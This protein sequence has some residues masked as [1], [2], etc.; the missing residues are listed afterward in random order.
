MSMS[1]FNPK[2]DD[3]AG[4]MI[5]MPLTFGLN[6]N[7]DPDGMRKDL[8]EVAQNTATLILLQRREE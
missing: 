7:P 4:M 8:R 3:G 5:K 6:W 2:A 1:Q